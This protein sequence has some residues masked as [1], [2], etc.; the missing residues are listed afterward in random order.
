MLNTLLY[1]NLT[2][3]GGCQSCYQLA[4]TLPKRGKQR[5][6]HSRQS[7]PVHSTDKLLHQPASSA[8]G[9]IRKGHIDLALKVHLVWQQR[10]FCTGQM[11]CGLSDRDVRLEL[12]GTLKHS[13]EPPAAV[14]HAAGPWTVDVCAARLQALQAGQVKG[15]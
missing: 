4:S 5:D 7:M 8:A 14:Q 10:K 12:E 15:T 1:T 9:D 6:A 3:K 13:R 11:S 2:A